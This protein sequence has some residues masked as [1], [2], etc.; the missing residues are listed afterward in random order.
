MIVIAGAEAPP[1]ATE[2]E[3]RARAAAL[4]ADGLSAREVAAAL[5]AELGAPRNVA[6]RLA[7]E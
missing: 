4:R 6:Y 7:H 2:D 5:T 1:S 3:L